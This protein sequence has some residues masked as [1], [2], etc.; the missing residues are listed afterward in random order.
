[1][2]AV[3]AMS[4]LMG[5]LGLVSAVRKRQRGDMDGLEEGSGRSLG[6]PASLGPLLQRIDEAG[7]ELSRDPTGQ[8]LDNYR[9]LLRELLD[10]ALRENTHLGNDHSLGLS[11]RIFQTVTRTDMALAELTDAV[12]GRQKDLLRV[13]SIV[14]LLKGLIVDLYR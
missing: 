5:S 9:S 11:Q 4:R 1:M 12:L 10:R 6:L 13:K 2:A 3:D 14:L 8:V 7:E